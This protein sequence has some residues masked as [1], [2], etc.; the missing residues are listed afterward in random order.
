MAITDTWLK[1]VNGKEQA[2]AFEKP[3]RDGLSVRVSQKG[4][5]T[6]QM[7]FR[8][9]G[10]SARVD[11]G[12]YPLVT[13]KDTRVES[14]CLKAELQK[15]HDP[16]VIKR[17]RKESITTAVTVEQLFMKW[18]EIFC[19]KNYKEPVQIL[20]TFQ[21]HVFPAIG[22]LPVEQVS[23]HEWLHLLEQ[24]AKKKPS[25]ASRILIIT[26]KILSWAVKRRMVER[27]ELA[28]IRSKAD[29]N[30]SANKTTRILN[31]FDLFWLFKALNENQMEPKSKI[32]IQ[33]MLYFGCRGGE[34]RLAKKSD[35][36]LKKMVWTIPYENHKAG[37]RT[38]EALVRPIIKDVMPLIRMAMELSSTEYLLDGKDGKPMSRGT[39]SWYPRSLI[40]WCKKRGY[41]MSYWSIHDLRRTGRTHLSRLT[42][43]DVAEIILG[44]TLPGV[45]MTYDRHDYLEEQATAYKA[46][47]DK[48]QNIITQD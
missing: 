39:F 41:D 19:E 34:L 24:L 12:T 45:R 11:L 10:K 5:I 21:L 33:L 13:L 43:A 28:D 27:N 2:K 26:K 3:D 14:Q 20:R 31:D 30:V 36:D 40:I 4:K 38:K 37:N 17:L 15:G 1:S 6:F 18:Y 32:L 9:A 8:Y 35:F 48:V 47:F 46:W 29:L 42:T 44:H 23:L 16:R 22:T 7:R 25:I